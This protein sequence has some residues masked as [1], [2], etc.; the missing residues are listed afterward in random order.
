M[1]ALKNLMIAA[2]HFLGG[3]SNA[4]DEVEYQ[5]HTLTHT[6]LSHG[7]FSSSEDLSSN[8]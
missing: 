8:F 2:G 5:T 1:S 6:H 4:D 3:D 7:N